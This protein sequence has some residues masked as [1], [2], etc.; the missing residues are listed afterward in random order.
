MTLKVIRGPVTVGEDFH[1]PSTAKEIKV[2]CKECGMS[3]FGEIPWNPT[4]AQR[5][6]II[7]E[8]VDIHRKT[9]RGGEIED[10]RTYE[11]WYPR[12]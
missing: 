11:I 9:C 5:I 3:A 10:K 1:G 7:R 8:I 4:A 6:A 12:K 2:T